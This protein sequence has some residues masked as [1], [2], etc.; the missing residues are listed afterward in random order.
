[1]AKTQEEL[2]ALKKEVETL[3]NKLKELTD[4]ELA[5]VTGGNI[6]QELKNLAKQHFQLEKES[7]GEKF[8]DFL[9]KYARYYRNILPKK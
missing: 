8:K 9:E 3:N 7:T 2:N 1:M 5:Q 6:E 4:E